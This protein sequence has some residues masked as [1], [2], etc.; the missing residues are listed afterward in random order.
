[1]KETTMTATETKPALKTMLRAYIECALWSST[2]PDD[3]PLDQCEAELSE[4]AQAQMEKDCTRFM[5]Y[6]DTIGPNWHAGQT[7]EQIGHDFWLTRNGHGAGFW[8]RGLGD[9][10]QVLTEAS[11]TFGSCDL[12]V[13]DNGLIYA[14]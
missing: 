11:K 9:L 6:C 12:Y 13:G 5:D 7:F 3:T 2:G 4:C 10:G 14:S 8:D 1:M